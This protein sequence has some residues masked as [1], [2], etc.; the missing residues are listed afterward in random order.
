MTKIKLFVKLKIPDTT[1]ITAFH[2][3]ER[4]GFKELK[5]LERE[6]YYEFVVLKDVDKFMKNIVKVDVLVN[7]NKHSY[8]IFKTEDVPNEDAIRVIVKDSDD[9]ALGLLSTL[10]G[11]LGFNDI[12]DVSRGVLWKMTIEGD[13][14][15]E[16]AEKIAKDL[17][18]N[19][20]YQ[21]IEFL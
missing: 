9:K 3:L 14:K 4:L 2:T 1:A 7:A 20:N 6:D 17:L 16:I 15:K 8:N 21:E 19:E 18:M 10:K 11:R 13:N 5:K 12:T